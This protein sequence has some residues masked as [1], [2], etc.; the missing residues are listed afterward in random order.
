MGLI[1]LY[2]SVLG[3]ADYYTSVLGRKDYIRAKFN[4]FIVVNKEIPVYSLKSS[5]PKTIANISEKYSIS[6]VGIRGSRGLY[7]D[8]D[9]PSIFRSYS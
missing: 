2:T 1:Y 8:N 4:N 9:I 5:M 6:C 3:R 7:I